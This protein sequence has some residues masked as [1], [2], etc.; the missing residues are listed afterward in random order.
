MTEFLTAEEL[1]SLQKIAGEWRADHSD[2][3]ALSASGYV[4]IFD[5]EVSGWKSELTQPETEQPGTYAVNVFGQVF[6]ASGY[7]AF[8]GADQWIEVVEPARQRSSR[9]R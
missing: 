9:G 4:T 8:N 5:G 6:L 7:D 1:E 3:L 2:D